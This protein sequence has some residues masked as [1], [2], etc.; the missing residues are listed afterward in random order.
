MHLT[1]KKSR[2]IAAWSEVSLTKSDQIKAG[3][4]RGQA[5]LL[6]IVTIARAG[7]G[8]GVRPFASVTTII[9][10]GCANNESDNGIH[11]A[12]ALEPQRQD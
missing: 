6:G 3:H 12:V 7:A 8:L 5:N 11:E 1:S 4:Q 2:A 10:S 9:F